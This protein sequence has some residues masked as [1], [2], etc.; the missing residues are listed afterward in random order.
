ME[1]EINVIKVWTN[2]DSIFIE[3]DKGEIKKHPIAWFPRLLK[4]TKAQREDFTLSP[5]GI[6]WEKLDED[7]SFEGFFT[8]K[9]EMAI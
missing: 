4:A 5:F 6:H 7:L 9:Q 8:F 3:T 1:N 2:E